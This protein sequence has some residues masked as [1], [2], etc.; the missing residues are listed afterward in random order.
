MYLS[1]LNIFTVIIV[2]NPLC[3]YCVIVH[4]PEGRR[5]SAFI[6]ILTFS[7][8]WKKKNHKLHI[9]SEVVKRLS[10]VS[11]ELVKFLC[12]CSCN[13]INIIYNITQLHHYI[14][15]FSKMI[16]TVIPIH[17]FA[18]TLAHDFCCYIVIWY[19]IFLQ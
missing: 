10:K 17:S 5:G 14:V 15:K 11:I 3:Y 13:Y 6:A 18:I 12:L 8:L 1:L 19:L 4:N 9:A 2:C 16:F 7:E